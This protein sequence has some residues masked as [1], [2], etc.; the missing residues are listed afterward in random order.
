MAVTV[1]GIEETRLIASILAMVVHKVPV[2][3][4]VSDP[5]VYKKLCA[6]ILSDPQV[7]SELSI[8]ASSLWLRDSSIEMPGQEH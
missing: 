5:K 8:L 7:D 2:E 6:D 4:L 1:T 3:D